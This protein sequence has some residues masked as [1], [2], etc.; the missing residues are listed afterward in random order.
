MTFFKQSTVNVGVRNI[1]QSLV[2]TMPFKEVFRPPDTTPI[3]FSGLRI[4]DLVPIYR[5]TDRSIDLPNL[6]I[7]LSI[8]RSIY[9]SIYLLSIY[10][11]I[12]LS[13]YQSI[14][15]S[16][17]PSIDPSVDLSIFPSI[18][19]SI[20][21]SIYRSIDLSGCLSIY[22]IYPIYAIYPIYPIFLI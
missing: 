18:H 2:L 14:D 10:Q 13:I 20:H 21:R 5:S 19:L 11:S 8:D 1:Q 7:Y 12:N 15:R 16:I 9:R 3:T 22:P 4:S 6:S 17:Y